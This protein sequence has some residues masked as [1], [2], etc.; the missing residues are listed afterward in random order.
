MVKHGDTAFQLV[1]AQC[2][3]PLEISLYYL[4]SYPWHVII[5]NVFYVCECILYS[6]CVCILC[7]FLYESDDVLNKIK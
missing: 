3:T 1:M 5:Y 6:I 7:N 4:K 2:R